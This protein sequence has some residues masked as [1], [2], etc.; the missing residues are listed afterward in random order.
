[1]AVDEA[2]AIEIARRLVVKLA[3]RFWCAMN[4]SSPH[5]QKSPFDDQYCRSRLGMGQ[6]YWIIRFDPDPPTGVIVDGGHAV[7][8]VDA[9]SG[10]AVNYYA[11]LDDLPNQSLETNRR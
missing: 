1:M 5:V 11:D 2:E 10:T 7:I 9:D 3:P 4:L 6:S 8:I